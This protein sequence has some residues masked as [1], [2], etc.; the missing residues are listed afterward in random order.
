MQVI[1]V[2]EVPLPQPNK[3]LP[4]A[5]VAVRVLAA[6]SLAAVLLAA[7]LLVQMERW[8]PVQVAAL[9]SPTSSEL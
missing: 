4:V 2:A 8:Q 9:R 5:E 1:V 7:V 6:A 3:L